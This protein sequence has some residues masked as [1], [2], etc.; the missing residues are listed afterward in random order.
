MSFEPSITTDKINL[1]DVNGIYSIYTSVP[2]MN[3]Y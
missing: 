3:G 2:K 1:R